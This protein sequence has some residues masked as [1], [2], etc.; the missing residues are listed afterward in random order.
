MLMRRLQQQAW[1]TGWLGQPYL[2]AIT[3][4]LRSPACQMHW[5][6]HSTGCTRL[7]SQVRT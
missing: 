1:M 4:L 6:G 5:R 3:L 7:R 2:L